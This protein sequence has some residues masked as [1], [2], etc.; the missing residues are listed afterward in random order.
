MDGTR[1]CSAGFLCE[2]I[3][4]STMGFHSKSFR[5]SRIARKLPGRTDNEIKNYWR[6]HMRKKAQEIRKTAMSPPSSISN[7]SSSSVSNS[8]PQVAS[9]RITET[10]SLADPS[11]SGS[12]KSSSPAPNNPL[13]VES[14]AV[15]ENEGRNFHH[16][17]R[18]SSSLST[19]SSSSPASIDLLPVESI[20]VAENGER[21]FY[22]DTGE[23][24]GNEYYS[25]D[26]I[27]REI[28]ASDQEGRN[29]FACESM[30]SP[31][32]S[33]CGHDSP[34]MMEE[35]ESKMFGSAIIDPFFA[36]F[37]LRARV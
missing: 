12:K 30:A 10:G 18:K 28:A 25:M 4:R 16:A 1:R 24:R 32:W 31:I 34:W 19:K 14:I 23:E 11:S 8:P 6:T 37:K 13:P 7:F 22:D 2:P 36:G 15:V 33:Y 20:A 5:W 21:S 3:R 26:E 27:W 9:I 35:D 29:F 17:I